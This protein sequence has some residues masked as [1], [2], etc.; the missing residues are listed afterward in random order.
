MPPWF[1]VVC[2]PPHSTWRTRPG[3]RDPAHASRRS[4]PEHAT[5]STR[6]GAARPGARVPA[7]VIVDARSCAGTRSNRAGSYRAPGRGATG[8]GPPRVCPG[9]ARLP[10]VPVFRQWPAPFPRNR[11]VAGFFP[12]TLEGVDD[13][14][15]GML[16]PASP[17]T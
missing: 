4:R 7:H 5:R 3:A 10:R 2:V 9:A 8:P 14:S 12:P 11:G 17:W 6:P 15:V 13:I 1:I 16:V